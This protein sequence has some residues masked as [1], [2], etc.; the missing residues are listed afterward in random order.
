MIIHDS[1]PFQLLMVILDRFLWCHLKCIVWVLKSLFGEAS[2]L[3]H[4][5]G[6]GYTG[7]GWAPLTISVW[8]RG[9]LH[10]YSVR[11][12]GSW[13][14]TTRCSAVTG[15]GSV[16]RRSRLSQSSCFCVHCDTYL[17][18]YLLIIIVYYAKAAVQ[19]N[20]IH[21]IKYTTQLWPQSLRW[22]QED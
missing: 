15:G 16:G 2:M 7:P 1:F 18:T 3:G 6:I 5:V 11:C 17:L 20:W 14:L 22:G 4:G 8:W 21:T 9:R 19:Y 12:W 13:N 10:A